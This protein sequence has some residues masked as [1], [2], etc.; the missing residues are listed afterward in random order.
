MVEFVSGGHFE[1]LL[2]DL[3]LS[4]FLAASDLR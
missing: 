3:S 2:V 1:I 4:Q